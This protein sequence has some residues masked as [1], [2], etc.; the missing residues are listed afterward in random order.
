MCLRIGATCSLL[1]AVLAGCGTLHT[2]VGPERP[3]TEV[4]VLKGYDRYYLVY[5]DEAHVSSVDGLRPEGYAPWTSTARL[6]PGRH[7]VEVT[8]HSTVG[9]YS[10]CVFDAEF[11]A[12]RHYTLQA[13]G[14]RTD[15]PYLA[16]AY[17][18]FY[19]G[20]LVLKVSAPASPAQLRKVDTLCAP[21]G[22]T[23]SFCAQD[24]DCAH[25][26]HTECRPA[27]ESGFGTCVR[28]EP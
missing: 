18:G 16:Q 12:G 15:T 14:M 17:G 5:W 7:W 11:E 28:R 21:R 10:V 13:H 23:P 1:P 9:G 6:L 20:T 8:R 27:L 4:A 24:A 26:S 2:W 19:R 3:D 25:L 22:S